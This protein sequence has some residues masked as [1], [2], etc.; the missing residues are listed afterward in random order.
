VGQS[1]SSSSPY[2]FEEEA[3]TNQIISPHGHIVP[4]LVAFKHRRT[5]YLLFPWASGGNLN[6][7]WLKY[8]TNKDELKPGQTFAFWYSLQW[9][10]DE[11]WGLADGLAT[12]HGRPETGSDLTSLFI[13]ADIKPQ[14]IL[15]FASRD[16]MK[17]P[18]ILKLA[19]FGL[20]R[21]IA[22]R[23]RLN[24]DNF[25]HTKTYRPPEYDVGGSANLN[26]D[27]WCLGCVFLEFITWVLLGWDGV[28]DFIESRA[29]EGDDFDLDSSYGVLSEDTFFKKFAE[30]ST[31]R[32]LSKP[33]IHIDT[34]K[35]V[36]KTWSIKRFSISVRRGISFRVK[37]IVIKVGWP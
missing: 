30:R 5:S 36:N 9:L 4:L 13:H 17:G 21:M 26:Y 8:T 31:I 19:D 12:V 33:R 34:R 7:I 10:L 35:D 20:S 6:D 25:P 28:V 1:A 32:S 22:P 3:K 15:C 24:V 27:V 11:C 23:E 29:S 14:N 37:D 18:F 16:S 2:R